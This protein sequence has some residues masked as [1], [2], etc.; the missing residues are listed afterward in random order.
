MS[1]AR[2]TL[3]NLLGGLFPMLVALVTVPLYLRFIGAAEYGILTIAWLLMGY[4]TYAELGLGQSVAHEI[5]R[6]GEGRIAE[7]NAVF[8]TGLWS[9][10]AFGLVIGIVIAGLGIVFVPAWTSLEPKFRI[11]LVHALPWLIVAAPLSTGN[12]VL[13]CALEGRQH[14]K[15]ANIIQSIGWALAQGLP[16]ISI[17]TGHQTLPWLLAWAIFGRAFTFI[18]SFGSLFRLLPLVGKII[19]DRSRLGFL[20][21]FGGWVT[22][23]VVA[24]AL[25][26]SLDRWFAGAF[27]GAEAVAYYSVP[28]NLA[29]RIAVFPVA[30]VRTLFPRFSAMDSESALRETVRATVYLGSVLAPLLGIGIMLIDPF[31]KLWVGKNFAAHAFTVA[32]IL[33]LAAWV[34]AIAFMP[35]VLLRATRR[36]RT[37]ASVR[38]VEIPFLFIA[39]WLG[40]RWLGLSGLAWAW[41]LRVA[42]DATWLWSRVGCL[43]EVVGRLLPPLVGLAAIYMVMHDSYWLPYYAAFAVSGGV[44][45]LLIAWALWMDRKLWLRIYFAI[46]YKSR[47]DY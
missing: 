17:L 21:S 47:V 44:V 45:M 42:F 4:S 14:F 18:A 39:S 2:N 13:V 43:G 33:L 9:A 20:L 26:S 5:A 19:P 46:L 31:L 23:S 22:V 28:A 34:R 7:R 29:T 3:Y 30:I 27:L 24:E 10:L 32:P 38:L 12:T 37:V 25:L 15:Q 6:L 40:F 35:D 11:E 36:P 16:L 1:I 8:W 41:C